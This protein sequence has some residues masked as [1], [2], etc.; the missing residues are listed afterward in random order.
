MAL[1]KINPQSLQREVDQAERGKAHK[2]LEDLCMK[3]VQGNWAQEEG[4]DSSDIAALI[5]HHKIN[6][7][8][9][10]PEETVVTIQKAH[11][12]PEGEVKQF[13][14]LD[15]AHNNYVGLDQFVPITSLSDVKPGDFFICPKTEGYMGLLDER[16]RLPVLL[17][18][19]NTIEPYHIKA[20][21]QGSLAFDLCYK[22]LHGPDSP[23]EEPEPVKQA[24]TEKPK[25]GVS[26][27]D[28]NKTQGVGKGKKRC[29]ACQAA[30]GLRTATCECGHV[31]V[32]KD[33]PRPV[34]VPEP[35]QVDEPEETEPSEPSFV[36][37]RSNPMD[38]C[39]ISIVVPAGECPATLKSTD[40]EAVQIWAQKVR[41]HFRES[42]EFLKLRGLRYYL[43]YFYDIGS[44]E[45]NLCKQHLLALH[46]GE[47]FS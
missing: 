15:R 47:D 40:I 35:V 41:Q 42:K 18:V 34:V 46:P 32:K 10:Q 6:C 26:I 3:I 22:M 9:L 5:Q 39:R 2:S 1:P 43:R 24:T 44:D 21:G 4:L 45:F 28:T 17:K 16:T 33:T 13:E 19:R 7:K 11:K 31:F 37:R 8:T 38:G 29:P 23:D 20:E 36:P 14:Y 30:V 25:E 27:M 12:A